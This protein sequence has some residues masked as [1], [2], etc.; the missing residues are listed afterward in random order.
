MRECASLPPDLVALVTSLAWQS[1]RAEARLLAANAIRQAYRIMMARD[2][3]PLEDAQRVQELW[4]A[5]V[6][7]SACRPDG[8]E[9][10]AASLGILRMHTTWL[11]Q[12][13]ERHF[14]ECEGYPIVVAAM[15]CLIR[16]TIRSRSDGG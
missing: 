10:G 5:A 14:P 8:S 3:V 6:E 11:E 1:E 15:D 16:R 7:M 4:T 12:T 2:A 13:R 9:R